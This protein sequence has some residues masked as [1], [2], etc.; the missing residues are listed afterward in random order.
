[1]NACCELSIII[2]T[3]QNTKEWN[4]KSLRTNNHYNLPIY[5]S[6][7]GPNNASS[8]HNIIIMHNNALSSHTTGIMHTN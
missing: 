4:L 1:M 8:T 2:L 6:G 5:T 7:I 3:P